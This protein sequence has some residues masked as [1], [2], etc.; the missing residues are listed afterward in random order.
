MEFEPSVYEGDVIIIGGGVIGTAIAHKLAEYR[1]RTLVLEKG[2][3]LAWG[4]SKA[5]SG[6]IHAG[7]NAEPATLK[8]RLLL[9]AIQIMPD[10]CGKLHVPFQRIGALVVAFSLEEV[11]V[12]EKLVENGKKIGISGLELLKGERLVEMEPGINR[13]VQAALYAPGGGVISPYEL[14]YALGENAAL[15]GVQFFFGQQVVRIR[16]VH[17]ADWRG[18]LER[19]NQVQCGRQKEILTARGDTFYAK[20]VINAAGLFA[21]EI[22]EMVGDRDFTITP[23]KGEYY[24]YEKECGKSIKHTIFPVP[25]RVS[26]GILVT[27][28][29]DGNLLV[30]PNAELCLDK[31]DTATTARGLAEVFQGG[32]RVLPNLSRQG[33]V[34]QYAGLRAV[35]TETED[36][37]IAPS[38]Q[39]AGV[40]HAAG[41][42]SP[43]LT[44]APAV[45]EYV[46]Q[47]LEGIGALEVRKN[48]DFA[49]KRQAPVRFAALPRNEQAVLIQRDKR[50]GRVICRCEQVTE[51][52]IVDA[53]MRYPGARTVGGVKRRVRA[54]MGRCQG[55]FC[56]ARIMELLAF[57]LGIRKLELTKEGEGSAILCDIIRRSVD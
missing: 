35:I 36:F 12:V 43:G 31:E 41:I 7:F 23:R 21:D 51:A 9:R 50:F 39:M 3:D 14:T 2:A 15:N 10:L 28:T 48:E 11:A 4:T 47:I 6:I 33:M 1:M 20:I 49:F 27:P 30:G 8:G 25:S 38:R 40:I 26:K 5:N 45:A 52:E 53:I 37:Y 24:L 42:Q 56:G 13:E 54:G 34:N 57:H 29:V 19:K 17:G 32:K 22:A 46:L 44:A 16:E 55:G 18:M